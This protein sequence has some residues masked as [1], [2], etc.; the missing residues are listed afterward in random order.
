[1]YNTRFPEWLAKFA[2]R[3]NAPTLTRLQRGSLMMMCY[4]LAAD[5]VPV[6]VKKGGMYPT[7]TID[8]LGDI[9]KQKI[10]QA[11]LRRDV[12]EADVSSALY[13]RIED[14][15]TPDDSSS[16][17]LCE[18]ADVIKLAIG[19]TTT[20]A[21]AGVGMDWLW[22]VM[23]ERTEVQPLI[24]DLAKCALTMEKKRS[25]AAAPRSENKQKATKR[26]FEHRANVI[27]EKHQRRELAQQ[28]RIAAHAV[29]KQGLIDQLAVLEVEDG[30]RREEWK[31][32][33][34]KH[35]KELR[36]NIRR[37]EKIKGARERVA[38]VYAQGCKWVES[39]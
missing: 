27:R 6:A 20:A 1:M 19:V 16:D 31:L 18:H 33:V 35:E 15:L 4:F 22:A 17:D 7:F 8:T 39:V 38:V 30:V 25:V 3:S 26:A 9:Q 29:R 12:V 34:E 36:D 28:A 2:P 5:H 24:D 23:Q 14:S 21:R 13:G 11:T 37:E 32:Q 10:T